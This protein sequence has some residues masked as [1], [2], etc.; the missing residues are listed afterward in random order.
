[1]AKLRHIAMAVNNVPET[2][3]FYEQVFGMRRANDKPLAGA[4]FLTDGVVSLAIVDNEKV[5]YPGLQGFRGLHH[6]GFVVDDVARTSENFRNY[7]GSGVKVDE[8][9]ALSENLVEV[10]ER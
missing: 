5:N 6:I 7:G 3:Q 2:V 8:D 1:M 10:N 9:K 4:G